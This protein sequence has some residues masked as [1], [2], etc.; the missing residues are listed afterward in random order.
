MVGKQKKWGGFHHPVDGLMSQFEAAVFALDV[1][2]FYAFV[3][4]SA[5][6]DVLEL[7]DCAAEGNAFQVLAT[8]ESE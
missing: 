5:F 8:A 7:L 4:V 1:S 6:R 3:P 2:G